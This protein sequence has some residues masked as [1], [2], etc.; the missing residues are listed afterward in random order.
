MLQSVPS[1]ANLNSLLDRFPED[2]RR[3]LDAGVEHYRSHEVLYEGDQLPEWAHFPHFGMMVSLTR[4][5][6]DGTT[7]EVGIIGWEGLTAV[8]TLLL[9]RPA[10][11]TAVIQ[12][13]GDASRVSL[14]TLRTVM[15]ENAAVRELLLAFAGSFMAQISQHA[16]CNRVH[17]IEQRLA[18]WLLSARDRID[19][20]EMEL[21]HDFL[22]HMLGTRRAGATVAAGALALD[23]LIEQHRGGVRITDREGLEARACECY[24][25]LQEIAPLPQR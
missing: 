22:S 1:G 9:P 15:N 2:V 5:T 10:G 25:A 3:R 11:T 23:G 16:T 17:T 14:K 4:A 12:I 7:V 20:D 21:T 24:R 6:E 19:T 18:K 8:Q 13:A